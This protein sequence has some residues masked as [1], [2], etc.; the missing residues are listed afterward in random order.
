MTSPN[1]NKTTAKDEK[2]IALLE[3]Q[4]R[5]YVQTGKAVAKTPKQNVKVVRTKRVET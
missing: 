2:K 5:R 1:D 3:E 4:I